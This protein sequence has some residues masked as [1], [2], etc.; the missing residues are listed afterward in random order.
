MNTQNNRTSTLNG[1]RFAYQTL[2]Q[3]VIRALNTQLGDSHQLGVTRRRAV[4]LLEYIDTVCG[5]V[6]QVFGWL[7][8]APS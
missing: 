3:E 8:Y 7:T 5:F 4:V 1:M 6:L 2:Q